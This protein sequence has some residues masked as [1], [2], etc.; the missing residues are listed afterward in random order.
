MSGIMVSATTGAMNSLLG[1]LFTL[2]GNEF[3]KLKNLRKQ[4]DSI[5][6]ELDS[7]K[8]ALETLS[9]MDEL[10]Q[11]TRSWRD[12]VRE[13]S[14][15]IEDIVD[16]FMQNIGEKNR[17]DGFASNIVRRLRTLRARHRIAG[18]IE[19]INKCVLDTSARRDRYK[20][21]IPASSNVTVDPRVVVIYKKAAN[22]VG[23]EGPKN[24]L[25]NLV[26]D[27]ENLLKVVSIVGFGG[28]GKTT[29][30]NE[31]YRTQMSHFDCGAFVTVSQKPNIQNLIH[32]LLYELGCG[33]SSH[34]CDLNVLLNKVREIL[35][36]KRYLIVID[37]VWGVQEWSV[38]K[39]AFPENNLGSRLIVTT[40]IRD[41]ANACCP[42]ALDHILQMKPLSNEDSRK[43]FLDR[44]FGS[45]EACPLHLK[46]VLVE[47]LNKCGGLPLAIVSISSKLANEGP[48]QKERWEHV[49]KFLGS[50][51]NITLE[52]V[53]KILNLS[54][55]DLPPHLKT[56]LLYL[57]MYPED[58][59]INTADLTRQWMAEGFILKV[60]G[61]DDVQKTAMSYLNELINRNLIQAVNFNNTGL[62]TT[63]SVH[64]MLLDLIL[65]K[66]AEENFFTI[67]EDPQDVAGL[68]HKIRRLSIRWR[69]WDFST[70]AQTRW[71]ANI[72][73]SQV[74]SVMLFGRSPDIKIEPPLSEF[75]F[76][77]VIF[78]DFPPGST[79]D[80]S[81]LCKLYQL[82]FLWIGCGCS[83]ELPT[84][85]RALQYLETLDLSTCFS[86]PSDIIY[87]T[88][89]M[90]MKFAETSLPDGIAI[91]KSLR[92]LYV[93]LPWTKLD[94]IKE[95]RELTNLKFL[96][97]DYGW[98]SSDDIETM[99]R[100]ID[101][102]SFS[103]GGLCNLE[104]LHID[105][106]CCIDGLMPVSPPST[107]HRLEMLCTSMSPWFSR[108]PNWIGELRNLRLLICHLIEL[109]SDGVG[110]LA[111]LPLLTHLYITVRNARNGI[112]VMPEKAFPV[113]QHFELN[114]RGA[115]Y[116]TFQPGAL[117]KLK[118]LKL[119]LELHYTEW[120]HNA[121]T[122]TGLEHLLALEELSAGLF[123]VNESDMKIIESSLRSAINMHP[124]NPRFVFGNE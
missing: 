75:K 30:A 37:D 21:D 93:C 8:I 95:I 111:Q 35:E 65:L 40:R 36:H 86:I 32:N 100:H 101:A 122:P 9:N 63:C 114:L 89:L 6:R 82:R 81:G 10:D 118:K 99:E 34:Y 73:V 16:D 56:C 4:V 31:V 69:N 26:V 42:R 41:V 77:R 51:T 106:K 46:D 25:V 70:D 19:D 14:Y 97:V 53:R 123:G 110:I 52:G 15:D 90:F 71:P 22:L 119:V 18:Q 7:M 105:V 55:K 76:L 108:V 80:L 104:G 29:L 44:I 58:Y 85:I 38:I 62:V 48:N 67:V 43:L 124:G 47:I 87:L 50:E 3:A 115:S 61:Q 12:I 113:L 91:M 120:E 13:M 39:C 102:L 72:A 78:I 33:I 49:V 84:Q 79:L 74:R 112:I 27:E 103:L 17:T 5:R 64:D 96:F 45:E 57:G 107:A 116:L 20:L 121:V 59:P 83:Y 66:A 28:L 98:D 94:T 109:L 23:M 24:E 68:H 60:N 11:R 2:T 54:Y 92:V 1:K 88:N 117:P